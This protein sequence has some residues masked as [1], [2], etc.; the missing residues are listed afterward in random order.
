MSF[1]MEDIA[2]NDPSKQ[3]IEILF[4]HKYSNENYPSLMFNDTEL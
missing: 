4:S 1:L 2:Y 3:A